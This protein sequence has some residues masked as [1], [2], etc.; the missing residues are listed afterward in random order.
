MALKEYLADTVR[1]RPK[2]P[3]IYCKFRLLQGAGKVRPTPTTH[4]DSHH[5][6]YKCDEFAMGKLQILELSLLVT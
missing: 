4:S 1:L 5:T 6:L 3:R 2:S